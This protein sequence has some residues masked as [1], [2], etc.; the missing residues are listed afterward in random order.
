[1]KCQHVLLVL[2]RN[3]FKM[4]FVLFCV[5][6]SSVFNDEPEIHYSLSESLR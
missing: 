2:I 4:C 3:N 6:F 1:M 5:L